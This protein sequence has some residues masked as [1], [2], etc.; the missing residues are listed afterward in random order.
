MTAFDPEAGFWVFAYGSLLWRPGFAVAEQ[1]PAIVHGYAR[2]FCLWSVHYRGTPERPGLVLALS[3][4]PSARTHGLA[5]RVAPEEGPAVL[6]YLRER[7]LVSD[8]YHEIWAQAHLAPVADHPAS[9][10]AALTYAIDPAHWQCA[11]DLSLD[12]QAAVI[13]QSVGPAGPN[14]EYLFNTMAHLDALGAEDPDMAQ[15]VALVRE[16]LS[17]DPE[18]DQRAT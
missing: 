9:E 4:E 12:E 17:R 7:E 16:R 11:P 5:L 8:A 14:A 13:A 18:T 2:R 1:R 3:P 10:V 6:A 15:L